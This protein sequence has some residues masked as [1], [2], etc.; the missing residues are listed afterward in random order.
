M[1]VAATPEAAEAGASILSAGGNAV[2]AAVAAAFALAV[3]YPEAGNLAGGGFLVLR[4]RDGTL[5]ALD[6]RET[7]PAAIRRDAF[8]GPDGKPV[9][10]A[11]TRTGLAV[12]VPGSV[13]G[14]EAVHRRFGKLPWRAVV[15][16]AIRLAREGF[17]VDTRL[18]RDLEAERKL[19]ASHPEGLRVFFPSG[20]P[21]PEGARFVQP[22]LARTL[23]EIAAKGSDA[24]H[25]GETAERIA[26]F[27]RSEGGVLEARDLRE[28]RPVWREPFPVDFGKWRLVTMPL[29][30][31]GG[32]VVASVLAQ[33]SA[34]GWSP[35]AGETAEAVHLYFEAMR[36]A[37]ADRNRWLGD[38]DAVNA[39]PVPFR[40]LL[41]AERLARMGRSIDPKRA[42]LSSAIDAALP[43][44]HERME[45]THLSV[46]TADGEAVSLTTTLNGAFGNGSVVPGVGVLLNNE[47]DD[48]A[49]APGQPNL[50]GL[51]QGEANAVR[52]GVRPL[53]SMTPLLALESGKLRF[54]LGSPGGSTIPGTV[55]QVFLKA[56]L[57]GH[58]LAEAVAA[59]RWHHQHLPDLLYHERAAREEEL[60]RR[61]AAM[62][63]ILAA[64]GPI[65]M[66]H[67]IELASDGTLVGVADPRGT[68]GARGADRP[69]DK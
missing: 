29:P 50:F 59:P 25:D 66:V 15:A 60:S 17:R 44:R 20:K 4:K 37:F 49:I 47:M 67:A 62:G 65:G 38:A 27:V 28:Y 14:Y 12:A 8:L 45:T 32:F 3:T 58:S 18:A 9:P 56:G 64:R 41:D 40:E 34:A 39:A 24:F 22:E 35:T 51:V 16:P 7:A 33:L 13:R 30:S 52:P 1:A 21:L 46:A 42:T 53:S 10:G 5:Y 2:D 55:L 68:G 23:S 26:R 63:H 57:L 43:A 61:L 48:F 31:S 11:S 69:S 54:V 6:F 36:R 19:F